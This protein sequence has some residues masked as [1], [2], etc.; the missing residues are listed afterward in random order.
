MIKR[1]TDE[2]FEYFNSMNIENLTKKIKYIRELISN[3]ENDFISIN[4]R[5]AGIISSVITLLDDKYKS[6]QDL[7]KEATWLLTNLSARNSDETNYLVMSNCIEKFIK[8]LQSDDEDTTE[9]VLLIKS[10]SLA[11]INS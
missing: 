4:L 3:L 11:H 1:L 7:Q 5:K 2:F 8:L 6:N 10:F 9:C